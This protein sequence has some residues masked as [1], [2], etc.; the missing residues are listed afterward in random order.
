VLY[1]DGR[2]LIVDT[3]TSTYETC[4]RRLVERR[5]AAHNTVQ[6]DA[7]EQSEVWGSFRVARRAYVR[8]L[9]E[10]EHSIAAWHTGCEPIGARHARE[11]AFSDREIVIRDSVT[12]R[13]DHAC[14][15]FLHFHPDVNVCLEAN[16]VVAEGV[17]I[18]FSGATDVQLDEYLYAP[19]FN[20][21][22][23]GNVVIVSFSQKLV[24]TIKTKAM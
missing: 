12:S 24:T 16:R 11:F 17:P 13:K 10:T 15:A 23:P 6:V 1:R 18:S 5:T 3:G 8:D 20:V 22:L 2:P 9:K 4:D 19:Q 7:A 21:L 14:R